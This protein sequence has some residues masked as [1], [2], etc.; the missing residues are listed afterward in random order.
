M[1]FEAFSHPKAKDLSTPPDDVV[2]HIPGKVTAVFDGASD[3]LC[4]KLGDLPYG[5]V[6]AMA[7]AQEAA[8]LPGEAFHWS[9]EKIL[10]RLSAAIANVVDPKAEGGPASTS[11]TMAFETSD[12]F[13]IVALGDTGYRLN[14]NA[15]ENIDLRPDLVS[16]PA[17]V[18]LFK[19]LRKTHSA[20]ETENLSQ[21]TIGRGFR[22]AIKTGHLTSSEA[23]NIIAQAIQTAGLS[24]GID[25]ATDLLFNGLMTQHRLS[26]REDKALGYGILN[27]L[28][29][30]WSDAVDRVVSK[31]DI[32]TLEIFSDGYLA[33]PK[34]TT[35]AAWEA[36]HT[37]L[38]RS[39]PH[40][41]DRLPAVKGSTK[42]KFFDDRT[43]A[44]LSF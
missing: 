7:A 13:R 33:P 30:M 18:L 9:T 31:R 22:S 4:R 16:I 5:R 34:D 43:V 38:E 32:R 28:D 11:A 27:G 19:H 20:L 21:L 42:A 35:I 44:I 40:H 17:R 8:Q 10:R 12:A 1:Q 26:N 2:L 41:I 37:A 14:G 6:A 36:E 39:D 15:V 3:A 24:S 25:E 29:P 23:D